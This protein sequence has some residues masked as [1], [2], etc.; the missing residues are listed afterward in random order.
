MRTIYF[1]FLVSFSL[2]FSQTTMGH[3]QELTSNMP[4][5]AH[6]GSAGPLAVCLLLPRSHHQAGKCSPVGPGP[7]WQGTKLLQVTSVPLEAPIMSALDAGKPSKGVL[8]FSMACAWSGEFRVAAGSCEWRNRVTCPTLSVNVPRISHGMRLYIYLWKQKANWAP[9]NF[10]LHC[11][12]GCMCW[13]THRA[14]GS[15]KAGRGCRAG[16][17]QLREANPWC[18]PMLEGCRPFH[19]KSAGPWVFFMYT[20][21]ALISQLLKCHCFV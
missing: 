19:W 8:L 6:T 9:S 17:T 14:S 2:L 7:Q 4:V 12:D 11:W 13:C 18:C 16:G 3:F 20:W 10:P 1:I 15:R 21:A 5:L